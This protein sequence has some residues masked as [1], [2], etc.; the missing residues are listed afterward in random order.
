MQWNTWGPK[1]LGIEGPK[2]FLSRKS[3]EGFKIE[4]EKEN[5]GKKR[6]SREEKK[7]NRDEKRKKIEPR[8]GRKKIKRKATKERERN[9]ARKRKASFGLRFCFSVSFPKSKE[10]TK[11]GKR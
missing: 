7:E 9:K 1:K 4:K 3:K 2:I 10:E 8:R 5:K 11:K 6:K